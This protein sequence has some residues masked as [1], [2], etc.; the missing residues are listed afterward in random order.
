MFK[1]L[2]IIA[3]VVVVGMAGL[4]VTGRLEGTPIDPILPDPPGDDGP[5]PQDGEEDGFVDGFVEIKGVVRDINTGAPLSFVQVYCSSY[6]FG[7]RTGS[8]GQYHLQ[9]PIDIRQ[10][11]TN[12]PPDDP[13]TW[14]LV[15]ERWLYK[16]EFV[17][18]KLF[19]DKIIKMDIFLV[20][21]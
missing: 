10:C 5:P 18:V 17:Q 4:W 11:G 9:I 15:A 6:G 14:E 13:N 3:V 19:D 1:K 2:L 8:D 16:V 20:P 7:K 12:P 21:S